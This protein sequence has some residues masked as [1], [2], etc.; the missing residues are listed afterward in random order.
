[1]KTITFRVDDELFKLAEIRRGDRKK[2]EFY[3]SILMEY[4]S[5]NHDN[6]REK[7]YISDIKKEIQELRNQL[8]YK[9]EILKRLK[10]ERIRDIQNQLTF[11]QFEFQKLSS[12]LFT[13]KPVRRWWQFW[14]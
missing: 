7:E 3:R 13:A 5:N 6:L 11:L 2:S 8:Q 14:K 12:Q 1:M 9:D 10:D 4:L